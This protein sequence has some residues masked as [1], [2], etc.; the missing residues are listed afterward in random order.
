MANIA[1]IGAGLAG[2]TVARTLEKQHDVSLF[3]KSRGPGG[4]IA[5]RYAGDFEFD[6]GAQYFTAHTK[7]FRTFL[8]P[9]ADT[10]IIAAWQAQFAEFDRG[11][12][13]SIRA[14]GD[15]FPHYVGTPRMNSIG[16]ALSKDLHIALETEIISIA[17]SGNGWTLSDAKGKKTDPFDWLVMTPPAAQVAALTQE[18]AELVAYCSDRNMHSCYALML[19]FEE[20]LDVQWQAA[21][22]HNADIRWM[23]VNSSKP[24]RKKPFTLL[25]HS[26]NAWADAHIDDSPDRVLQHMFDEASAVTG[27]DLRKAAHRQLHRWRYANSDEQQAPKF[28]ID[29]QKRLAA[30]GDWCVQGRVEAAFTSA[31]DLAQALISSIG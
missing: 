11:K 27:K 15:E 2:L 25:L 21:L 7:A 1:I 12:L 26:T 4:R 24:G 6:H 8:K 3:E 30:C 16:K 18:V 17:R 5:T 14:W 10:G 29:E 19:G 22:V 28:F 13:Q 31:N 9:L 23:S 20:P